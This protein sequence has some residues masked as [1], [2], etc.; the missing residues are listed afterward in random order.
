MI[1]LDYSQMA[2]SSFMAEAARNKTE[3]E[4]LNVDL[5]RHMIL[6][7]IRSYRTRFIDKYGDVVIA[8]DNRHYWRKREY[9]FYKANR[10]KA[11]DESKWDWESIFDAIAIVKQELSENFPYPV[12]DVDG[13][14]ADDVIGTL[15]EYTTDPFLIVSGDHDFKQLQRFSHVEQYAPAQKKFVTINEPAEQVLLEHIIKGDRG[16]GIP[17][18][19]SSDNCLVEGK[20]QRPIRKKI[21]AEWKTTPPEEWVS[22]AEMAHGFTRNQKL[23]DLTKT[24]DTIKENIIHS[25]ESQKNQDRESVLPYLQERGLKALVYVSNEF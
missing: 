9:P 2:I 23:I 15:A 11:R 18:M 7:V 17:N 22:N 8:C 10:R 25:Y 13:A 6:N 16:D 24:P 3:N 19:L 12:I 14:E 5:F 4:E 21:L 1:I 20:R